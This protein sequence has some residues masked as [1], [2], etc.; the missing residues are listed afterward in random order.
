MKVLRELGVQLVPI[1]LPEKYPLQPLRTIGAASDVGLLALA[2][3]GD[4]QAESIRPTDVSAVN[5]QDFDAFRHVRHDS[6]DR[7]QRENG[8]GR[9]AALNPQPMKSVSC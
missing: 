2:F 9:L 8:R 3:G 7:E 6:A 5:L 1:K 4:A